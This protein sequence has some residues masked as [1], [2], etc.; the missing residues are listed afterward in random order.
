MES[1]A[2]ETKQILYE[3]SGYDPTETEERASLAVLQRRIEA[4]R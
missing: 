4:L 2:T 1:K 3:L